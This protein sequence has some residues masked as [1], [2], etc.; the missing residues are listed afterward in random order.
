MPVESRP[1]SVLHYPNKCNTL[2][3]VRI[4]THSHARKHSIADAEI[5]IVINH[6]ELRVSVAS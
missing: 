1:E 6:H 5:R 2:F 4:E 3:N